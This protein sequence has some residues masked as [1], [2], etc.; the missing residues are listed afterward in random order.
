MHDPTHIADV[1]NVQGD[2]ITA[3]IRP[4]AAP[5]LTFSRGHA[6]F[7]G[8]VGAYVRI[9]LGLVD[10]FALVVQVGSAP[11]SEDDVDGTVP[12]RPWIRLELLGEAHRDG[13][14]ERGVAR[15][16]SI[17]DRVLLVTA[18]DLALLYQVE[19]DARSLRGSTDVSVG[20]ISC[21]ASG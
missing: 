11:H 10:L 2:T 13:G 18:R 12:G 5:G 15:Y 8:Q 9:P 20:W 6:Y 21:G 16:P 17:G 19:D 14:F 3:A 7:V 4:E 1:T